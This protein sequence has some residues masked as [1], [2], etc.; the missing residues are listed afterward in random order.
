M[1]FIATI[2]LLISFNL[3]SFS[4]GT[5]TSF[6]DLQRTYPRPGNAILRKQDLLQKEFEAKGLQWPARYMYIR[7]FKYDGELEVWVTVSYTHL[8]LPTT[9]RV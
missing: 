1:K 9:E 6:I 2:I 7:S 8:T 4:Q 3:V 5:Y